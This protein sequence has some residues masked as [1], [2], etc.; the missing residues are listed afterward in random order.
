MT[1]AQVWALLLGFPTL[2][3][4]WFAITTMVAI[5]VVRTECRK[6]REAIRGLDRD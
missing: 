1:E 2:T 5:R 6:T 4:V 3:V